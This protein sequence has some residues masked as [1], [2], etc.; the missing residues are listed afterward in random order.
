MIGENAGGNTQDAEIVIK[1]QSAGNCTQCRHIVGKIGRITCGD[2]LI[3]IALKAL[4]NEAE[5]QIRGFVTPGPI[6]MKRHVFLFPGYRLN[7][8][9]IKD[10]V[11]GIGNINIR[12]NFRNRARSGGNTEGNLGVQCSGQ[13]GRHTTLVFTFCVRHNAFKF[14]VLGHLPTAA[15]SPVQ[16]FGLLFKH[17]VLRTPVGI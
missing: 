15:Q 12:T 16:L 1:R 17:A 6:N 4:I 3:F 8:N 11:I 7:T 9:Q 10:K 2:K 14:K 5:T 13:E